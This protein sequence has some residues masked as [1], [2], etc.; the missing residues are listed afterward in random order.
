MTL[1]LKIGRKEILSSNNIHFLFFLLRIFV[2]F[3]L[4]SKIVSIN[5]P[6]QREPGKLGHTTQGPIGSK[7]RIFTY[8][9]LIFTV[10][11]G[12]LT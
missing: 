5:E 1:P 10:P 4:G 11:S 3:F 7:Y 8:I 2:A 12:K 6:R 9:H